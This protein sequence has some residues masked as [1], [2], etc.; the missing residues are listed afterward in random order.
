LGGSGKKGVDRHPKV[1][2]GVLLG[3]GATL[4]GPVR[5]GKSHQILMCL[6]FIRTN[7]FVALKEMDVKLELEL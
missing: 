4:L 2:N 6:K 7:F 3:A 5:I 1:G